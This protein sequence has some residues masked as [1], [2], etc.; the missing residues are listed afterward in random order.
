MKA[1]SLTA[2]T[3]AAGLALA[4]PE[5]AE[6]QRYGDRWQRGPAH[7]HHHGH[8]TRPQAQ[9]P[10]ASEVPFHSERHRHY[11]PRPGYSARHYQRFH[12]QARYRIGPPP[13]GHHYRRYG[14]R[15]VLVDDRNLH[16]VAIIG[17]LTAL[18][19]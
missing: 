10:R 7:A 13:R 2:L 19:H 4:I 9:H 11:A 15:V 12:P 1:L 14:D 6:A 8:R 16:I 17:L 18:L 3:A 5:P